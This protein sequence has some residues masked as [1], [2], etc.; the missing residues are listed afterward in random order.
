MKLIEFYEKNI[1]NNKEDSC[2]ISYEHKLSISY[3]KS[4]NNINTVEEYS[5]KTNSKVRNVYSKNKIRTK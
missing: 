4:E 5:F 1:M 2:K 3:F